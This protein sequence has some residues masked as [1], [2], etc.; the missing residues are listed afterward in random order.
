MRRRR[1]AGGVATERH[2]AA[3]REPDDRAKWQGG[4][5]WRFGGRARG[6]VA[7]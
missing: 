6:A 7:A 3:R 1:P 2:A 4:G 5:L